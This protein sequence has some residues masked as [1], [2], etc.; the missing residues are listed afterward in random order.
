MFLKFH[1]LNLFI[2]RGLIKDGFYGLA[3]LSF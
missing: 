3:L 2:F 1:S